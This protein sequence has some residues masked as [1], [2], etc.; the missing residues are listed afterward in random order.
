MTELTKRES[1]DVAGDAHWTLFQRAIEEMNG[2]M[3]IER[4]IVHFEL[5][6]VT[7]FDFEILGTSGFKFFCPDESVLLVMEGGI[8][9]EKG[10]RY[11][12]RETSYHAHQQAFAVDRLDASFRQ[13]VLHCKISEVKYDKWDFVR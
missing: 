2:R 4:D 8:T 7:L 9:W 3:A 11:V 1:S 13:R 12:D 5:D 6:L 10:T